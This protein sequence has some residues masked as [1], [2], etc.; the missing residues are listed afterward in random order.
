MKE[1]LSR[2]NVQNQSASLPPRKNDWSG[3]LKGLDLFT[4]DFMRD[5]REQPPVQVREPFPVQEQE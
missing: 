3:F 2:V 5:G 4:D 1:N